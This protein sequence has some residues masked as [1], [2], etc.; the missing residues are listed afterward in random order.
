MERLT[1]VKKAVIRTPFPSPPLPAT[2]FPWVRQVTV[3]YRGLNVNE[4]ETV[5]PFFMFRRVTAMSLGI[6]I[7]LLGNI[8]KL[9]GHKVKGETICI[10]ALLTIPKRIQIMRA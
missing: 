1:S 7:Q 5:E 9:M 8:V 3:T 4:N 10:L 2:P 6:G